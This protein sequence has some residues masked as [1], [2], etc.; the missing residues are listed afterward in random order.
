VLRVYV[1]CASYLY[2]DVTSTDLIKIHIDSAKITLMSFDDF[3]GKPL[4]RLLERIKIRFRDQ[5]SERFA[6]RD[7][8]EPPYLYQKSRFITEDFPH[9]AEQVDFEQAL[10]ARNL[11]YLKEGYGPSPQVFESRLKAARL[12]VDGFELK[13]SRMLPS[14]DERCGEHFTF[15]D[16]IECGETQA[17]TGIPN[18][19]AQPET[20]NALARLATLV[21]DPVIDYFGP[22]TLTYGFCSRELA[23]HIPGR[24]TPELDQHA[25]HELNTRGKPICKRLGAAVDFVVSDESMLEVAQW[26]INNTAFDRLYFYGDSRPLHVSCGPESK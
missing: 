15:R 25:S 16:L 22:I 8:Y 23:K 5:D 10:E 26:I 20:Y 1:G 2:G 7:G 12:E 14:L 18:I 21:L 4:P 19:P 24:I 9:Y 17:K 3:A 11:L 6:Y 13:P